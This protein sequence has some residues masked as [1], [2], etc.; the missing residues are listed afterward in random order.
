MRA[1]E[2]DPDLYDSLVPAGNAV[3]FSAGLMD[4]LV[5]AS[6]AYLVRQ[7]QAGV[8]IFDTWAGVLPGG[9]ICPMVHRSHATDRRKGAQ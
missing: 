2:P 3:G 8:Q 4:K 7:P 5:D 6:A 9:R 1:A